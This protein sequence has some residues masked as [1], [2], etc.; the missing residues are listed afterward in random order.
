M[1]CTNCGV[2][3]PDSARFCVECGTQAEAS[4]SP[5][6]QP[7]ATRRSRKPA[8]AVGALALLLA[9]VGGAYWYANRLAK[10][11]VDE[12]IAGLEGK[13]GLTYGKVQANPF[14]QTVSLRD[15]TITS[16]E[17]KPV[18]G[19]TVENLTVGGISRKGEDPQELDVRI[20]GLTLDL[21]RMGP[22]GA[23]W[24]LLGYGTIVVDSRIDYRFSR[25][26]GEFDL[27]QFEVAGQDL[28]TVGL[29]LQL[30]GIEPDVESP[31]EALSR[32]AT[33]IRAGELVV[34]DAVVLERFLNNMAEKEGVSPEE[35][36]ARL[37]EMAEALLG[38]GG[39]ELQA[40]TVAA[41]VQM[42]NEPRST[43]RITIAP[44]A[45]VS[46]AALK[47]ARDPIRQIGMLNL[48]VGSQG[49]K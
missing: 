5:A 49:V 34:K 21:A 17:G 6:S 39:A 2:E 44:E 31:N 28:M 7:Q 16:V 41:A 30:G 38:R 24:M 29:S 48:Q 12:V 3:L 15:I 45:P 37:A 32:P 4:P 19:V 1:F 13:V 47:K 46:V 20:D 40:E 18:D 10:Q 25:E 26:T 23:K 42:I 36:R 11:K 27:N 22:E 14:L 9:A 33:T 35:F 8:L 43:L